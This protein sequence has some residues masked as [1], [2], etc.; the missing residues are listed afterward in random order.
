MD[1]DSGYQ[2][3][4]SRYEAIICYKFMKENFEI[5]ATILRENSNL[6]INF[7]NRFRLTQFK[8]C[9]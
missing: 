4:K 8:S 2:Y 7:A 1:L 6:E 3:L 9:S 5:F